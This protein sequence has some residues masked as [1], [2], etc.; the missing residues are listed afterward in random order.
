[1]ADVGSWHIAELVPSASTG[2]PTAPKRGA[3]GPSRW[4]VL[5][6]HAAPASAIAE[7]AQPPR[8]LRSQTAGVIPRARPAPEKQAGFQ[9]ISALQLAG[10][11]T[12]AES[13]IDIFLWEIPL[14]SRFA[15]AHVMSL[16]LRRSASAPPRSHATGHTAVDHKLR[17]RHVVGRIGGEEQ[18]AIRDVLSLSSP[19]ERHPALATSLGSIGTLRTPDPDS[20]VQIGVS[21]TPG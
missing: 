11:A 19:A 5:W 16:T 4:A 20:F 3:T 8:S 14:N 21:M 10:N 15:D 17:P 18:H 13:S 6:V 9:R 7:R 2:P 1:M 12:L